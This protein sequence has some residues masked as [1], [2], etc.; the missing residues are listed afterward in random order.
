MRVDL[1]LVF[2]LTL[3]HPCGDA[4][5]GAVLLQRESAHYVLLA[6]CRRL[7]DCERWLEGHVERGGLRC[8]EVVKR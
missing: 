6:C 1:L 8:A 3:A 2:L 7:E 5:P 4:Q